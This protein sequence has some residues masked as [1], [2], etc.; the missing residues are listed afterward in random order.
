V[1][2]DVI[3]TVLGIVLGDHDPRVFPVAAV[4]HDLD[5]ASERGVVV[6]HR[7]RGGRRARTGAGR[8]VVGQANDRQGRQVAVLL[9]G[10]ELAFPLRLTLGA[11]T[12]TERPIQSVT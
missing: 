5:H 2:V 3:G 8:V 1:R 4:G 6:G 7:R 10:P 9:E 11:I 12:D